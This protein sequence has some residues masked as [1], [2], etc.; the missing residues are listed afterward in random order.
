MVLKVNGIK[1]KDNMIEQFVDSIFEVFNN[2]S[3][4]NE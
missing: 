1:D 3:D 2:G 4:V